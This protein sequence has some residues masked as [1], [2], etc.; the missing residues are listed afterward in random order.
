MRD[1]FI[2]YPDEE[3]YRHFVGD[4][5]TEQEVERL[6]ELIRRTIRDID[7]LTFNRI[8]DFSRLTTFQQTTLIDVCTRF[9]AF[10][11][12]NA[13]ILDSVFKSYSINGV[14]LSFDGEAVKRINGVY[15]PGEVY[16]LL[17]QTGLTCRVI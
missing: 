15:I 16:S 9:A 10:K 3:L 12:D 4:D 11:N 8:T 14:S 5:D 6:R 2:W 7:T 17:M 1:P 13:D